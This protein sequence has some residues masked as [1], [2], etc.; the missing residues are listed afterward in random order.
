[1]KK[2]NSL[3]AWMAYFSMVFPLMASDGPTDV[4]N[5]LEKKASAVPP[6]QTHQDSEQCTC[7][8]LISFTLHQCP[9]MIDELVDDLVPVELPVDIGVLFCD[10]S[11]TQTQGPL[12]NPKTNQIDWVNMANFI[13]GF[14][15]SRFMDK[16]H[17]HNLDAISQSWECEIFQFKTDY[18]LYETY[19]EL[20]LK[21]SIKNWYKH[22]K[23]HG[24]N[25]S[26]TSNETAKN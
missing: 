17:C 26:D 22:K 18:Q 23:K 24:S 20:V 25:T 3:H 6:I 16:N 14:L 12:E 21:G 10:T 8:N 4:T 7:S 15:V 5:L 1:M 13:D 2:L 19:G 11:Y 9:A